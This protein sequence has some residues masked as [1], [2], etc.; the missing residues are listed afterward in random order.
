MLSSF[1]STRG[2]CSVLIGKDGECGVAVQTD[3]LELAAFVCRATPRIRAA[4]RKRGPRGSALEDCIQDV[5]IDVVE[6][7]P[8]LKS[9]PPAARDS[10]VARS[11][12]APPLDGDA[13]RE[14]MAIGSRRSIVRVSESPGNQF[15]RNGNNWV[16]R[17]RST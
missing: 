13:G 5:L 14:T 17:L 7:W 16:S 2:S 6:R 12:A 8:K 1:C 4:L 15:H 3:S 9:Y 11:A 10:Y